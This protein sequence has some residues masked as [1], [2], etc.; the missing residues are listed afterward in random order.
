MTRRG[1]G[2][3][4]WF[5]ERTGFRQWRRRVLSEPVPA[6]TGWWFTLGWLALIGIVVEVASG[7]GLALVYAPTSDHAWD[8]V[9]LLETSGTAS[10]LL[11]G[12]H[13]WGAGLV[14]AAAL[15]HLAR[16]AVLGSYRRPR[17]VTWWT[18]LALLVLLLAL[19]ATGAVLPWDQRAYWSM[20]AMLGAASVTPWYVAHVIVLPA[21]V[22]IL[23]AKHLYLV[24]RHGLS[25]PATPQPGPARPFA[26]DVLRRIGVVLIA[27]AAVLVLLAW[28]GAP[29]LQP[30]ADPAT[31]AYVSRPDWYFV[32]LVE[33]TAPW[34][35]GARVG[36]AIGLIAAAGLFLVLLPWLDRARTREAG[37]RRRVLV[38]LA[39]L[40]GLWVVATAWG[41][42]ATPRVDAAAW[43]VQE[44]AGAALMQTG[45]RCARC[46]VT[47]SVAPIEP[48]HILRTQ[49]WLS[50]HVADPEV[51][52]PGLREPPIVNP[53]DSRA[54]LAALARLRSGP[55]PTVDEGTVH[56]Y[57]LASRYCIDCH[58]IDGVGVPKG[59]DLSHAGL[60]FSAA[61]IEQWIADA[62]QMRA[63]TTMPPFAG[64]MDGADIRA[65]AEWLAQR[66]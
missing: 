35:A 15:L 38:P 18:G 22:A 13:Y 1:S 5:D 9:R 41:L 53:A 28:W 39:V 3:G 25:G 14:V 60:K 34:P 47:G 6:G 4:D 17:E 58:Q 46:H 32:G 42:R 30:P 43:N 23:V 63:E 65:L 54:M 29:A 61:T 19:A 57:T 11:R 33:A 56:L 44:I 12:L 10:A 64:F 55:P 50:M 27:A 52:A 40:L 48:G 8:S 7:L 59:P 51:L 62:R 31:R 20:A 21:L 49:D 24:W 36:V 45:P 26:P 37:A 66:K 2:I 16:A